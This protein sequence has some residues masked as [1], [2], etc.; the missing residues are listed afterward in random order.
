MAELK[1]ETKIE[2]LLLKMTPLADWYQQNRPTNRVIRITPDE[3]KLLRENPGEAMGF[4]VIVEKD[5]LKWRTF[6]IKSA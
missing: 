4:G 3:I 2:R 5:A 6:E 1:P